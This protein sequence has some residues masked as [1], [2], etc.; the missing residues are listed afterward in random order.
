MAR[1]RA[2]CL[3]QLAAGKLLQSAREPRAIIIGCG[4]AGIA[5][6]CRLRSQ[7]KFDNFVIYEREKALGGTWY[8]NTCPGVGCDVDSHLYSFF[9]NPNP[10][11]SKRFAEQTE[12]LQ[13]LN[14]TV[15]KFGVREHIRLGTDVVDASWLENMLV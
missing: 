10:G 2:R 9:F 6:A 1:P 5:L 13:Y 11:W 12:I 14:T 7:L 8:L 3:V 15:D 4:V